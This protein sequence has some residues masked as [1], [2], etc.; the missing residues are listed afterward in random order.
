MHRIRRV[1]VYCGSSSRVD[2][3]YFDLAEATGRRLA[4]RGIGVVYGGGRSG[5]MGVVAD[6]ALAAGGEVIGVIPERLQTLEIGHEGLTSLYVVDGMPMR[7]SMM[8]QLSDAF[9]ALPG[10]FGTWEEILEAA[11]QGMLNYHRKPLGVLDL[12]DYYAPLRALLT[13]AIDDRF[14]R[15]NHRDLL[16]FDTEVDRLID[17]LSQAV[18]PELTDWLGAVPGKPP[19]SA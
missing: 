7:K 14:V 13:R 18:I 6:A 10:G 1:A 3:K 9:V 5:L 12:D 16:L 8:I 17:R 11:T 2:Q 19:R 4:Q 15:E